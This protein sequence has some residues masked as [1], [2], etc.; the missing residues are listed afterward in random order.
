MR[1]NQLYYLQ[2]LLQDLF[3]HKSVYKQR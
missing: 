1:P 2:I 3:K